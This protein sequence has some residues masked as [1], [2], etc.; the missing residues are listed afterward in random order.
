LGRQERWE[1]IVWK[2]KGIGGKTIR[3]KESGYDDRRYSV[4][5]FRGK[6][7]RGGNGVEK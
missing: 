7:V 4:E 3:E 1:G 6:K 5:R 2:G